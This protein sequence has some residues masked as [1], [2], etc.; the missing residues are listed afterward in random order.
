MTGPATTAVPSAAVGD[1][2]IITAALPYAITWDDTDHPTGIHGTLTRIEE[3]D[4]GHPDRTPYLVRAGAGQPS[5]AEGEEVWAVAVRRMDAAYWEEE[6]ASM[7]AS[8]ANGWAR[9]HAAAE[10]LS[11]AREAVRRMVAAGAVSAE[12]GERLAVLLETS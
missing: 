5:A 1:H 4:L 11:E 12:A 2:V 10:R 6:A 7:A 3:G 9:Y 8:A